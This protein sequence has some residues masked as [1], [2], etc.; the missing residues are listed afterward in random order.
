MQGFNAHCTRATWGPTHSISTI[1]P[2]H[3]RS[4]GHVWEPVPYIFRVK[5]ARLEA[6]QIHATRAWFCPS[7]IKGCKGCAG[8]RVSR[9]A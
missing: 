2:T 1:H 7:S 9:E 3:L 4:Q 6:F 8:L 5:H